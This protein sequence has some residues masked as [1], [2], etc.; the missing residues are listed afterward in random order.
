MRLRVGINFFQIFS[1]SEKLHSY[2][3]NK[4]RAGVDSSHDSTFETISQQ[5]FK[6]LCLAS[7]MFRFKSSKYPSSALDADL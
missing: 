7:K 5:S 2:D 1:P 4:S 3:S 6:S